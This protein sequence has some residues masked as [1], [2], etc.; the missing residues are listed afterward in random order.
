MRR[1]TLIAIVLASIV[2]LG[3]ALMASLGVL[4]PA[5]PPGWKSVHAGMSRDAVLSLT[6]APQQSG[7]PEM[8]TETW[9]RRGLIFH[10]RLVVRYRGDIV[11]DLSEG[12]WLRGYGWLI[13]REESK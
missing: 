13:P 8:I 12:K 10:H 11:Q 4:A 2:V 5:A 9:E 3:I 6:G 7:W 1:K